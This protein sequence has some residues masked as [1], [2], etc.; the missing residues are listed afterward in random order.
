[1]PNTT[2]NISSELAGS[3]V[4]SGERVVVSA[5]VVP[6]M[7]VPSWE[8]YHIHIIYRGQPHAPSR[9]AWRRLRRRGWRV[10]P[11]LL[12]EG[13]NTVQL[14]TFFLAFRSQ[15]SLSKASCGKTV[16]AI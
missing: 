3:K 8:E 4:R 7:L 9:W 6:Q 11:R 16:F 15:W 12:T 10:A 1:M 2:P 13:R 5:L 14:K